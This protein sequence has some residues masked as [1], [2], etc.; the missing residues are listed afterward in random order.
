VD[1]EAR[2][3][4]FLDGKFFWYPS[5]ER[6]ERMCDAS[7]E[8][9]DAQ[10]KF[11]PEKKFEPQTPKDLIK[12]SEERLALLAKQKELA[13]ADRAENLN[14]KRE[15]VRLTFEV[16]IQSISELHDISADDILSGDRQVDVMN[17]RHHLVWSLLRYIPNGSL[18]IVGRLVG[19]DYSTILNSRK[20]FERMKDKFKWQVDAMDKIMDYVPG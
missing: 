18:N 9:I 17:A 20:K 10:K 16:V 15:F 19:R 1:L 14:S 3:A 13:D 4:E 2:M 11:R 5:K 12:I 6:D 8:I 7:R